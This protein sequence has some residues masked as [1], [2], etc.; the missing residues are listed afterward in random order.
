MVQTSLDSLF[1]A[2]ILGTTFYWSKAQKQSLELAINEQG[3]KE[4]KY[5]LFLAI[6]LI[7]VKSQYPYIDYADLLVGSLYWLLK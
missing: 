3:K 2:L 7:D 1:L 4:T 6:F 5:L